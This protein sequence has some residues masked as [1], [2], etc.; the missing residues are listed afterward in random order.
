[1]STFFEVT[2]I[3]LFGAISYTCI[4]ILWRGH[5]HPTMSVTG[6]A[7]FLFIYLF[8]IFT[9]ELNVIV[10]AVISAAVISAA[11]FTIGCIVNLKLG[12]EVWD[13]SALKFNFMGQVS[14]FYS[15]LW[16]LLSIG[17]DL[18]AGVFYNRIFI[19]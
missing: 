12:W 15:F 3:F 18:L 8:R 1:M 4:E 10:R 5:T 13:Y 2:V 14:L 9:P 11:E 17:S 6:G 7:C 16:F 19:R